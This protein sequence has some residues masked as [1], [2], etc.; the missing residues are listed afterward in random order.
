MSRV[1][2]GD[3]GGTKTRLAIVEVNGTQLRIQREISYPSRDFV[4][5]DALLADFLE[6]VPVPS[7]AAFGIAG[8]VQGRA[9]RVTQSALVYRSRYLAAT[10]RLQ[11]LYIA[12]RFGVYSLRS[13]SFGG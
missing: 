2:A 8:P 3:I 12:Q 4:T 10:L 1:V 5:F 6:D 9:V 11:G 7:R 13:A